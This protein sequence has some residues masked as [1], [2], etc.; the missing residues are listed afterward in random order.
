MF[1]NKKFTFAAAA[2]AR[3]KSFSHSSQWTASVKVHHK[4]VIDC[5][6]ILWILSV[7]LSEVS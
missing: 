1:Q 4:I 5:E 3:F 7:S 2:A 6:W